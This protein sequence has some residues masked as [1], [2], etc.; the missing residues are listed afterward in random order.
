MLVT[1][2]KNLFDGFNRIELLTVHYYD[3][4]IEQRKK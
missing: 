1:K 4:A 3:Y 2:Q